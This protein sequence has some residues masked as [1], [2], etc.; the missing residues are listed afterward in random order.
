MNKRT[1]NAIGLVI[2]GVLLVLHSFSVLDLGALFWL[3]CLIIVVGA[4]GIVV[5]PSEKDVG[6]G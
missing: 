5:T 1:F 3:V 6:N 2:L 4:A